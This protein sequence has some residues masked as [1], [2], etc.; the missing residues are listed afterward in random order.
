MHQIILY[1]DQ[2]LFFNSYPGEVTMGGEM[3]LVDDKVLSNEKATKA[4]FNQ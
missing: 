1:S 3:F 2:A 4:F